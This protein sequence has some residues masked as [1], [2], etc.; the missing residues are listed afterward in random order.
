MNLLIKLE[1]VYVNLCNRNILT[2]IS[3]SLYSNNIVTLIG[4]NGAGKSTLIQVIL[5]LLSPS[6]GSIFRASNLKIG[7]VPQKFTFDNNFPIS[8]N[9]FMNLS[10]RVNKTEIL[11]TLNKLNIAHL[12]NMQMNTLS[13]GEM[14]KVFLARA[15]LN[16]P[17]L[18]ILD[19]PVQGMD[20]NSQI[21]FYKLIN[22]LK[23]DLSYTILIVSHDLNFVMAQTD[24]VI[25]LNKHICCSG[26]PK[27]ITKNLKFIALFGSIPYNELALYSHYHNHTHNF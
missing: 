16:H 12:K 19:E 18:L 10:V 3:L 6:A 14:Q 22:Q 25:C 27:A 23:K 1:N 7:Y 5:N 21:S 17:Q 11:Y 26:T 15:L 4:P 9:K 2:N 24:E 20:I 8:V 13:G